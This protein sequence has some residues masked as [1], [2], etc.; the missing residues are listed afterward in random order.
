MKLFKNPVLEESIKVHFSD[1]QTTGKY[2]IIVGILAV[3][4][5]ATWPDRNFSYYLGTGN[6]PEALTIVSL[7]GFFLLTLLTAGFGIE[8]RGSGKLYTQYDWIKLTPL[9]IEKIVIGKFKFS[10]LHSVFLVLMISPFIII[11]ASASGISF[12]K[13]LLLLTGLILFIFT[14][15]AIGLF[16]HSII[17]KSKLIL[18]MV[19]WQFLL[20]LIALTASVIPEISPVTS[21]QRFISAESIL[22]I[23]YPIIPFYAGMSILFFAGTYLRLRS[24]KKYLRK[25]GVK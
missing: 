18:N 4:S 21:I 15:R 19:L 11:A 14:Y 6:T 7:I 1:N 10:F 20:L 8:S 13:I 2:I 17:T 23:E 5:F 9:S 22:L 24:M 16:L 12:L 3:S 25:Q